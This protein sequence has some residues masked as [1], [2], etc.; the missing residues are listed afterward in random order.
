MG[1]GWGAESGLHMCNI[2]EVDMA[3]SILLSPASTVHY[4]YTER[5]FWFFLQM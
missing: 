1:G 4:M 2:I 5:F 3:M